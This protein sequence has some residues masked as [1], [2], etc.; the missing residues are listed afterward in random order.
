MTVQ[1]LKE[2]LD[3][4]NDDARIIIQSEHGPEDFHSPQVWAVEDGKT[5]IIDLT[6]LEDD[7]ND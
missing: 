2:I 6:F 4:C 5:V 3:G 1:E 7:N